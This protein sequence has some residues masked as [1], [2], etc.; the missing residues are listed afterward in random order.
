LVWLG[1]KLYEKR[2]KAVPPQAF[3]ANGTITGQIKVVDTTLFKV[4]Q[5][6]VVGGGP[7]EHLELEVK[8]VDDQTTMYV[9]PVKGNIDARTDISAYT[10][11][12]SSF[13][14]ANE[15]NRNS[16]P[17]QEIERNTYEEEPVV[18]RRVT[19]IDPLGNKYNKLN[20]L[21]VDATVSVVVPPL[22]VDL[23][24]FGPAPD[25]VLSVGSE[26]GT[27]TGVRHV[28][29]VK[30]DGT[31]LVEDTL[32][33]AA[34][35]SIDAGIPA[36]LGQATMAASMPVAL[37]SDQAPIPVVASLADEPVK[38]SGTENGQPNGPEF[39]FVNNLRN[40]ILAAKDRDQAIAY[41]DFG[42]KNQRVTQIDYTA[43]SIGS[44]AGFTARKTLTYTL[45][46]NRYRRDNITW[47]L[48]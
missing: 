44:G 28:V 10:T 8:R 14:F 25:S 13:I 41:A 31:T 27:T 24:A 2:F 48:V 45:V 3:T 40:Q 37:A 1:L 12:L 21:P 42:T 6:V 11:A 26:D 19:L 15:Q 43:S 4:K 17:E 29:K 22:T 20:P 23:T 18:A 35:T 5:L 33:I 34:L 7:L 16:V 30:P 46:G 9:G 38:I 47:T 32:A 39:T 36:S